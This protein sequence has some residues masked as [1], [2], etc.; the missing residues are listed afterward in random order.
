M[1]AVPISRQDAVAVLKR[2]GAPPDIEDYLLILAVD[3]DEP[4][5]RVD[6]QDGTTIFLDHSGRLA[7]GT[8]KAGWDVETRRAA[9]VLIADD[10]EGQSPHE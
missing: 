8:F 10:R 7:Y 6:F 9:Y 2:L 5:G 1:Q 3:A 4:A